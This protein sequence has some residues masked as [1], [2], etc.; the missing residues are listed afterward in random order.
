MPAKSFRLVTLT[1]E[2]PDEPGDT[3]RLLGLAVILK[4]KTCT[5]S[6]VKLVIVE[7]LLVPVIVI[8]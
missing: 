1:T 2:T 6:R 8:V 3:V 4:S 7:E 5:G